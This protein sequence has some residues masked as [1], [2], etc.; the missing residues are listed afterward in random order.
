M[1]TQEIRE[2][3]M[4][5]EPASVLDMLFEYYRELNRPETEVVRAEFA[6][7][8]HIL[9]KLPHEEMDMVWDRIC[10]LCIAYQRM[11]F[12]DGLG[13]GAKVMAELL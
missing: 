13:I 10:D 7:I 5:A 9:E 2:K 3:L 8:S 6:H 4:A 1:E 11:A 12:L